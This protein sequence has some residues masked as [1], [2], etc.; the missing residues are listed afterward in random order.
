[1]KKAD[2]FAALNENG[3]SAWAMKN[4]EIEFSMFRSPDAGYQVTVR[5]K[6]FDFVG[7][8]SSWGAGA[9]APHFS[10]DVVVGRR[11][12]PPD[13]TQCIPTIYIRNS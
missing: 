1:L 9:A 11:T 10:N 2:S 6:G 5:L 8:G 7:A 12:G 4:D 13:A 3:F